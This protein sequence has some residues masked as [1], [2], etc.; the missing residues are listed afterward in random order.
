MLDAQAL[1]LAVLVAFPGRAR[2]FYSPRSYR[3]D[4]RLLARLDA[5]TEHARHAQ[6]ETMRA[7]LR[8]HCFDAVVE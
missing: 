5:L 1:A 4:P 2:R 6:C 8:E 7:N 3:R